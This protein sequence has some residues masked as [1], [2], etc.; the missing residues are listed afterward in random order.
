[1]LLCDTDKVWLCIPMPAVSE[2]GYWVDMT[3]EEYL[4]K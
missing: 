3:D 4:E 1:M 2:D